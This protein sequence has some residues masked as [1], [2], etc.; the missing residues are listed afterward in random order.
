MEKLNGSI[1]NIEERVLL[2][3]GKWLNNSSYVGQVDPESSN[4]YRNSST[5]TRGMGVASVGS[6]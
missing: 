5:S 1:T 3:G 4:K 6:D 2:E